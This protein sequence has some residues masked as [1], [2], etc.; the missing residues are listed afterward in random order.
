MAALALAP[1]PSA[2]EPIPPAPTAASVP[3]AID[4]SAAASVEARLPIAI[5]IDLARDRLLA[6]IAKA[7]DLIATDGD[8]GRIVEGEAVG[9]GVALV[10]GADQ[11]AVAGDDAKA[12]IAAAGG[13][14]Q[15]TVDVDRERT[16]QSDQSKHGSGQHAERLV[17]V[18]LDRPVNTG[19]HRIDDPGDDR[20]RQADAR[21]DAD[22]GGRSWCRDLC[23][24]RCAKCGRTDSKNN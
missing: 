14:R 23:S 21:A 7:G 22:Q 13:G 24:G 9:R 17:Y 3:M 5:E 11:G 8:A 18:A 12:D 16:R 2:T 4:S 1:L 10:G 19:Q 6:G 20:R 15:Q